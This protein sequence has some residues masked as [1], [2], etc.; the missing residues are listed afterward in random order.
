MTTQWI[1]YKPGQIECIGSLSA[2]LS[3][4]L[5]ETPVCAEETKHHH[6]DDDQGRLQR[7]QEEDE[8]ALVLKANR[9]VYPR[10]EMVETRDAPQRKA[11][12]SLPE[13]S[14]CSDDFRC[15][16]VAN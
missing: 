4:R 10:A 8:G 9:I 13:A 16:K 3:G 14:P 7:Q 6:V 2:H 12:F 11:R 5:V 1:S 15:A